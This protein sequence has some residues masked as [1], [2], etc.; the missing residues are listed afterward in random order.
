MIET[1]VNAV[2]LIV[3]ALAA[4]F[5]A[6]RFVTSRHRAWL[7]FGFASGV[8]FLSNL[9]WHLYLIFYGETPHFSYIPDVSWYAS[10][11][12][13]LML[14]HEVRSVPLPVFTRPRS[15]LLWLVPVFTA[16]MGVF[17][18]QWGDPIGNII[19]AVLMCLLIWQSINDL[20][21]LKEE[22]CKKKRLLYITV[23]I[24][25]TSEY[26]AW[27]ASCYWIGDTLLNP[28]IWFDALLSVT[29]I[30]LTIAVERAVRR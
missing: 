24:Y 17:Y 5:A 3:T 1:I 16:G 12:F 13:L 11:V 18:M 30:L 9:Y 25:C 6:Y 22:G 10:Y 2:Q 7:M 29:F 26:G 21:A 27:T 8:S 15:R 23:L 20:M 19:A 28:Y 4:G 14:M